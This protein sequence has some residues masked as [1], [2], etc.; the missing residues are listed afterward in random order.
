MQRTLGLCRRLGYSDNKL[1]VIVNRY[2]SGDVLP[3]KDAEELLGWPV[4]WSLPN[5]Y[6]L[7]SAALTRGVPIAV[8]DPNSKLARSYA[9]LANKLGG[10]PGPRIAA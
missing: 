7:S 5:D 8:E 4:F 9:D 2:Q 1:C 3:L 10:T 6:R